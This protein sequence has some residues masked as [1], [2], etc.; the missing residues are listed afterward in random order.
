MLHT[1]VR[2]LGLND[3]SPFVIS[4]KVVEFAVAGKTDVLPAL[5][6]R[7]F[8]DELSSS[9][10]APGG[11]SVSALAAA[12]A[13][14]LASMTSNITFTKKDFRRS[15]GLMTEISTRSQ[16]LK[17][18]ALQLI[19]EDTNAF[20]DY[21]GAIRLPKKTEAEQKLRD[22]AIEQAAK[23]ITI[24]PFE[25]LGIAAEA[26]ELAEKVLRRGIP[27]TAS[28][29]GTALAQAEASALGAWMNVKINLPGIKDRNFADETEIRADELLA[30]ARAAAKRGIAYVKRTFENAD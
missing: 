1:A 12:L 14:G 19:D 8:T 16:Q 11:G 25:T 6:C 4:D 28:D 3:T 27:S 2:S 22:E 15:R 17:D 23:N 9:S 29:S 24:V 21:I 7:A 30:S 20:N 5:S 26:A 10:I 13:A 18:R